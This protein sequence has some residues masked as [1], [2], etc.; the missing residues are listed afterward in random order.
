M[1]LKSTLSTTL[2]TSL[3]L[4]AQLKNSI[5]LLK[6]TGIEIEQ[7][8]RDEIS[9]NLM[10]ETKDGN[11]IDFKRY[12]NI[13]KDS[14]IQ[15]IN[16]NDE[17]FDELNFIENIS[18]NNEQTLDSF[19]EK[20]I[21][22]EFS[23]TKISDFI[24][25]L[26]V[27]IDEK[28]YLDLEEDEFNKLIKKYKLDEHTALQA[29][30]KLK[31]IEWLGI[32]CKDFY[33]FSIFQTEHSISNE[34]NKKIISGYFKSIQ[35]SQDLMS[36]ES[37]LNKLGKN[38]SNLE[39]LKK[40]IQKFRPYPSSSLD[41]D[42][43][44][45]INP[46]AIVKKIEGQWEIFLGSY[47]QALEI[48]DVYKTAIRGKEYE[49]LKSQ[50]RDAQAL[51]YGL[52]I[53]ESNFSKILNILLVEQKDFFE[54]GHQSIKPLNAKEVA[55]LAN[56][57]ESSVSRIINQK[58]IQTPHGTIALRQLFAK[59]FSDSRSGEVLSVDQ[60]KNEIKKIIEAED[61][62]KPL[63]DQKISDILK[64]SGLNIA[65]RTTT[66]YRE[67]MGIPKTKDRRN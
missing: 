15:T 14:N 50:L 49:A 6:L 61:K 54:L 19:L 58:Y 46:D 1:S 64:N 3:N 13:N 66:K 35:I 52:E 38:N 39:D 67:G 11:E 8:I 26:I 2:K 9:K 45:Y 28:G 27:N 12:T 42:S 22:L 57:S 60:I 34:K 31:N 62:S 59:G 36:L 40:I 10:L 18:N 30:E 5:E 33:E 4:S 43:V 65:R 25:E 48:N 56:I 20:N 21:Y 32:G 44:N 7:L 55:S 16:I 24:T 37:Y 29:I 23:D 41:F 63:S 51:L 47:H 17:S 53:R